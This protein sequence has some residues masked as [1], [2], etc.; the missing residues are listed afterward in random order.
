M[1][2]YLL[3]PLHI[4]SSVLCLLS[5]LPLLSQDND[6]ISNWDGITLTWYVSTGGSTIINN[7]AP[8]E[9]NPSAH[10]F[11]FIT[12]DG[13]YEYMI[14]ELDEPVN[15]DYC[16]RYRLKVL[17]PASGG[18]ITLKFENYN[19]SFSQEI[20]MTPEP[21][22]WTDLLYDFSGYVYNNLIKVVI[23]PDFEGTEPGNAWY[24]D[25]VLREACTPPPPFELE[26]NLPIIV[27]NTNGQ[28]I[29][30]EPKIT[31]QMGIISNGDG[32]M[33][34]LGDPFNNYDGKAAIEIR[35]Q[36]SQMFPKHSYGF[37]TRDS[38]GEDLDVSL[39][40]LPAENDWVLYAPYSDKSMLRNIM[41]YE[42]GRKMGNYCTR[43]V[44]CELVIND[45][46]QGVYTLEEKIKKDSS[47]VDIATLNPDEVTGDDVTGGYIFKVDKLDWDFTY[48]GDGWKSFPDPPY[49]DAMNIIFQYY[50]P[51]ADGMPVQQKN[52]LKNYVTQAENALTSYTFTM[53]A[54]GYRKYFDLLSFADFM[55]LSEIAKEVDKYR[56][57]TYFHKDKDSNGGRIF[58]GPAW[59]FD[60]GYGNVNYWDPGLDY[61][62]WLY[63]MVEPVDWGI[64]FWWKRMMEDPYFHRLAKTRWE[65]LRQ[66]RLSDETV[67]AM[68]DSLTT[69][70]DESKDRNFERWPI[71]GEYVW[72]NY[73]WEGNT[74]EDEVDYFEN[75]LFNRLNWMDYNITGGLVY[76]WAGITGSG[77]TIDVIVYDDYFCTE[78]LK[79]K[80]FELNNAP[81]VTVESVIYISPSECQL[82]LSQD[83]SDLDGLSV[84]VSEKAVNYWLDL[85]SNELSS[86]G[87]AEGDRQKE[88]IKVFWENPT[89]HILTDHPEN[90]PD[91]A[92]IFNI[93]GQQL[94][95]L[96]LQKTG[97]NIIV[98]GLTP[99]LYLLRMQTATSQF[100]YKFAVTE[101]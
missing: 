52:Y 33:N 74:Y 88:E 19:N 80:W 29:Q 98:T 45:D 31:V 77:N 27:I 67:H 14:T 12:D 89:L 32:Q 36:S 94:K 79:K 97:R 11:K 18:N 30:D 49:P 16:P 54:I 71:L 21:G 51:E 48:N 81:G 26:T 75:F 20:V 99:G 70:L 100:T 87:T 43:S 25:D 90:L 13:L 86:A 78:I 57:S 53:P 72:P 6:T 82:V 4:L 46:Y 41:S 96:E 93:S 42:M 91:V 8:D 34:H 17:A 76:P 59:D 65:W 95:T 38:Q 84:T 62:G 83:I 55:L 23:F 40:G 66:E 7:P 69:L 2:K 68:I 39:M 61:T 22:Q 58:A 63:E 85:T 73:D 56:Y 35:G 60:L 9:V 64:M 15:F 28:Q 47:R 5:S 24:I 50:Y 44:F 10:C 37:E 101:H 92:G 3:S 1:K